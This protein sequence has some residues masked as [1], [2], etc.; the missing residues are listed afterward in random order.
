LAAVLAAIH[1]GIANRLTATKPVTG[2]VSGVLP[3]FSAGLQHSLRR[4]GESEAL[5]RHIP[6]RYLHAYSE[7]KRSEYA[8]LIEPI[9]PGEIDFYL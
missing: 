3:E 9:L 1:Y 5:A 8:D 2:K 7:L 6:Q 4:L